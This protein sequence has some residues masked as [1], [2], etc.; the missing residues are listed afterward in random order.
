MVLFDQKAAYLSNREFL[1]FGA[2]QT[3]GQATTG[4]EGDG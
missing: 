1:R 2:G 3:I 4:G